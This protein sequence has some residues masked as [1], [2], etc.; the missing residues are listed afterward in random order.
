MDEHKSIGKNN[1]N[2]KKKGSQ[3]LWEKSDLWAWYEKYSFKRLQL[4]GETMTFI[5]GPKHKYC[6]NNHINDG[7]SSLRLQKPKII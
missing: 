4:G 7:I 1:N 6:H 3:G 5:G 2:K